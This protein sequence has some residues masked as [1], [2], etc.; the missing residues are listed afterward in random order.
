MGLE[1]QLSGGTLARPTQ[2]P[3]FALQHTDRERARVNEV[4]RNSNITQVMKL[5]G[6][7]YYLGEPCDVSGL[8]TGC[9]SLKTCVLQRHHF[10]L[11]NSAVPVATMQWDTRTYFCF[12]PRYPSPSLSP[13]LSRQSPRLL[14]ATFLPLACVQSAFLESMLSETMWYLFFCSWLISRIK[15][16]P[17]THTHTEA[18]C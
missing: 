17:H 10:L 12:L 3:A 2:G 16:T 11:V 6:L 14:T 15:V 8:Y 5:K 7:Y 13:S 4:G 9:R 1:I 18:C